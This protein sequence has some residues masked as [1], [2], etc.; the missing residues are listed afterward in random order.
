[1]RQHDH[2]CRHWFSRK[3]RRVRSP[4]P[5]SSVLRHLHVYASWAQLEKYSSSTTQCR[6]NDSLLEF[7]MQGCHKVLISEKQNL[8]FPEP[9][10]LHISTS[11][12]HQNGGV[13][14]VTKEDKIN[15]PEESFQWCTSTINYEYDTCIVQRLTCVNMVYTW[16]FTNESI[17]QTVKYDFYSSSRK[18]S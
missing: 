6:K 3:L 10:S 11:D 14:I 9:P 2:K 13:I 17:I 1:M 12:F 4:S 15:M 18:I 7:P 16:V 8:L 5:E